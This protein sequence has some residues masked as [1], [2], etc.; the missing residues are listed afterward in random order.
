MSSRAGKDGWNGI[1]SDW[2]EVSAYFDVCK[3]LFALENVT[4]SF[5]GIK[6]WR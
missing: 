2:T 1:S 6:F 5:S 4:F 3:W